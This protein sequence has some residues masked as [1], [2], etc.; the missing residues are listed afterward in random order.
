[1]NFPKINLPNPQKL[2][3]G[4]KSNLNKLGNVVT[5]GTQKAQKAVAQG[6]QTAQKAAT[7]GTQKLQKGVQDTFSNGQKQLTQLPRNIENMYKN[8]TLGRLSDAEKKFLMTNVHLAQPFNDAA[9]KGDKLASSYSQKAFKGDEANIYKDSNA[10]AIRHATWNAL[11]VK[12]A[13]DNPIGGGDLKAAAKKAYE[14]ATAHEDNPKNTNKKN[15]AMDLHNNTVGRNVALQVLSKNPK[16]S[17]AEIFK[18]VVDAF[19]QGKMKEV[20]GDPRKP[21]TQQVVTAR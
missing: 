9:E 8:S 21:E 14:F 15:M 4:A 5:Q 2:L 19:K 12:R 13:Y 18:A 16:A 1:M 20:V 11:M 3:S 10:N 7:Q 6:T 17:D